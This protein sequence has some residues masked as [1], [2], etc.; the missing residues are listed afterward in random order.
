MSITW[1]SVVASL[2][3]GDGGYSGDENDLAAVKQFVSD[4]NIDLLDDE[5]GKGKPIDLD[6]LHAKSNERRVIVAESVPTPKANQPKAP[7]SRAARL[8]DDDAPRGPAI[9]VAG[10]KRFTGSAKKAYEVKAAS[11]GIGLKPNQ[12][13]FAD[14]DTAE[15]FGAAMRL[16]F[17]TRSLNGQAYSQ[18]ANDEEIIAKTG[19]EFNPTTGGVLVPPEYRAQLIYLR[20]M[21]GVTRQ[22]ANV[23][24]M[25]RDHVDQ[26]RI[27]GIN[28]MAPIGE[29]GTLSVGD[30]NTDLV[31]LT[32]K[33]WGRLARFPNELL[34][35]AAISV[36]DIFSSTLVEAQTKAEDQTYF[37]GDGTATYNQD[38]GLANA[39]PSG[40]Y[41]SASGSAWSNI[42]EA[43]INKLIGSVENVDIT[44]CGFITSRQYYAQVMQPMYTSNGR[45]FQ[46]EFRSMFGL[47][48]G[49]GA[50]WKGWPVL[51]S[52]VLPTSSASASKGLYFGDYLS[53]SMLGDRREATVATSEHAYFTSDGFGVRA[54]SRFTVN[55][56]GDGRASTV[57]PIACLKTT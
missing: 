53:A 19:S 55:I 1:K 21:Y 15:F 44:R 5:P 29:N 9:H 56:H 50:E 49:Q 39:L 20:E 31:G 4:N 45:G 17:A 14:A 35:D 23:V 42:T 32:A 13:R 6:A 36:V 57:G 26:P 25:S 41:I 22:V 18:R 7:L 12:T 48:S 30:D 24:A 38:V 28:A 51:F 43:D 46:S 33:K 8:D 11:A 37:L 16:G 10:S 52:Q 2:S 40:A 47:T 54:I 27:T 34:D 3:K